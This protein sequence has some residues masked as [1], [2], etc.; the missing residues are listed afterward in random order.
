MAK[1]VKIDNEL[2]RRVKKIIKDSSKKIKYSSAKQ[3]VDFAVLELLEKE[4]N[5]K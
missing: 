5:E 2:L 4:G 3:F 1:A